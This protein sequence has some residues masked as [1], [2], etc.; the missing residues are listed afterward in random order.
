MEITRKSRFWLRAQGIA[1]TLLF[2]AVIGTL[3]WLST[4][5]EHQSDWT[6]SGR[7]TLTED[8]RKLLAELDEPVRITAFVRDNNPLRKSIEELVARYQRV[9]PDIRLEYVNPDTD[10]EQVREL[11]IGFDGELLLRYQGRSEK[12]Q[13]LNEQQLSNALLRLAGQGERWILFL[14]GHGER[15]PLGTAN[16]DLGQFGQELRRMGLQVQS[17]NLTQHPSIPDNARLLVIAS[18]QV[19]YLPGEV[20]LIRDHIQHGGNLLWLAEPGERMGLAPIAEDLGMEFLPGRIVD[21]NT[22]LFGIQNP[23]FVL[24]PE[25]LPHPVTRELR[26]ITLFPGSLALEARSEAPWVADPLLTTLERAW[27][28]LGPLEGDIQYDAD[29]DERPG[30][31]DIAMAFSREDRMDADGQARQQRLVVIGDGDF[32]SNQYLGNGANLD[33]GVNLIRWLSH[34]D[35]FIAIRPRSAPDTQ[36]QLGRSAQAVIAFGFLFV[37]PGLLLLSGLVIWLR[38]RGR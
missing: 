33:L 17:L 36:L 32:L 38:R 9:K 24:I 7:N 26:S 5:Y 20:R 22:A 23:D 16:H 14:A 12:V 13:Q 3:A 2:L 6:A 25:Y 4:R 1:S 15:D 34:D 21:A 28:E 29:T 10:P 31:L 27:T 37:L 8:S 19:D 18:P 30:P 35:A 11:G